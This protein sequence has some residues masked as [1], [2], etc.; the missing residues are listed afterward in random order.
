M[1]Y[2]PEVDGLRAVA[3]IPVILFHAGFS[4]FSGGYIGVDI[5]FV[6]SGYLI[7]TIIYRELESGKFSII[8]FYEKR[9]RRILPLLFFIV[10]ISIPL[11]WFG[12]FNIDMIDF[13]QSLVAIPVF[14]SNVLFWLEADYFD[15]ASEL[16]PLLH[17]W[18][19]AVEE[20]FYLFF[21]ITLLVIWKINKNYILPSILIVGFVSLIFSQWASVNFPTANFY[22]LP[23]RAWELAVG[24]VVGILLHKNSTFVNSF[25]KTKM[26]NIL[27]WTGLLMITYSI[28]IFDGNTPYPSLYTLIPTLG[29][30]LIICFLPAP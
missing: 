30:A 29:T 14:S 9:S 28:L 17:T 13:S 18:S 19:L 2:R 4:F 20:Q 24:S 22:L 3:V 11:A 12:L 27:S 10:F 6:I 21:P 5:F 25:N 16:K 1:K 23:S 8:N 26:A 15:T 7:T